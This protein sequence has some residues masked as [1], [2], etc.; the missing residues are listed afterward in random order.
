MKIEIGQLL[1]R[2]TFA[3]L[4]VAVLVQ[5]GLLLRKY[6]EGNTTLSRSTERP[7]EMFWPAIRWT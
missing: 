6:F 5:V 4:L 3:A 1:F 7:G 2:L